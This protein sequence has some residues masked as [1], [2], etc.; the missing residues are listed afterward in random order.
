M[1]GAEASRALSEPVLWPS[2]Y[3]PHKSCTFREAPGCARLAWVQL[4]AGRAVPL[5]TPAPALGP[6]STPPRPSL[7]G[8]DQ[9]SRGPLELWACSVAPWLIAV[10]V[11]NVRGDSIV[12][13]WG[14]RER[15][16]GCCGQTGGLVQE[17]PASSGRPGPLQAVRW[18]RHR[19]CPRS[20]VAWAGG[21]EGD[22]RVGVGVC[23]CVVHVRVH[24]A[25]PRPPCLLFCHLAA[26]PA[27]W[28]WGLESLS[29]SEG[30]KI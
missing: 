7:R 13:R 9:L 16:G 19:T 10:A 30:L 8:L 1:D 24:L 21:Q 29:H 23:I 3:S 28:A 15:G 25:A 6:P 20:A 22:S 5:R 4:V 17:P 27:L 26:C 14:G 18:S 11:L 12:G 2:L